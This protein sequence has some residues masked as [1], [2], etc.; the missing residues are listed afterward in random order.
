[1]VISADIKKVNKSSRIAWQVNI[2][3]DPEEDYTSGV[4]GVLFLAL[5]QAPA[6]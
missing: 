3:D 4:L 5:Q 1:M 6:W 2:F